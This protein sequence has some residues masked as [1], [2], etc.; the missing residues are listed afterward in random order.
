MSFKVCDVKYLFTPEFRFIKEQ[1]MQETKWHLEKLKALINTD[2]KVT[3]RTWG[4]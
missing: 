1:K 2:I 3:V 4:T